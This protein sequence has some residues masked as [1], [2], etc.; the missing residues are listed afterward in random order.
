[1]LCEDLVDVIVRFMASDDSITGP[2][3]IGNPEE[4]TI[5]ELAKKIIEVT[6]S[7]SKL[8]FEPLPSDDPRRRRPDIS[9][10]RKLLGWQP[11]TPLETGLKNTVEY[12]EKYLKR[13]QAPEL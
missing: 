11:T 6:G 13:I 9:L 10:A 3:N 4:L 12:F 1:M 7:D 5:L 2:L 8:L